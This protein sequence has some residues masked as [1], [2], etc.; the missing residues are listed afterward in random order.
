MILNNFSVLPFYN[1]EKEQLH[2]K[3]YSFNAVYPLIAPAGYFLPFQVISSSL[4]LTAEIS[5]HRIDG[6]VVEGQVHGAF[7]YAGFSAYDVGGLTVF[8]FPG[9]AN[10]GLNIPL[11]RYYFRIADTERSIVSEVFTVVGDVSSFLRL[12]WADIENLELEEGIIKYD[13]SFKH[14][15]FIDSELGKPEY[16]FSEEGEDR[17]GYF[18]PEKQISE[19]VYRFNFLAPEYLLDALRL[20]RLSDLVVIKDKYGTKY[21]CDSFLMTPSW[22]TQGNLASVRVEFET[23]T[24]VK[25]L[26][27]GYL[28]SDIGDFNRDFMNDYKIG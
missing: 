3:S 5:I 17:D 21:Q 6:S 9:R 26:G 24:V 22:Q 13:D 25:K 4:A 27:R 11:G 8:T 14:R 28:A 7:S 15:L 1:S 19:K 18:F 12:E 10:T 23:D 16:K 2:R 20:V